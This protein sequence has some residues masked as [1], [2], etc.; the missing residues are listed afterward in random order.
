ML[1]LDGLFLS[2]KDDLPETVR[3]TKERVLGLLEQESAKKQHGAH[4]K[5]I[6]KKYRMVR[7]FGEPEMVHVWVS[8]R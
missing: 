3:L 2:F 6:M 4:S 8:K 1:E 7:F 5:K